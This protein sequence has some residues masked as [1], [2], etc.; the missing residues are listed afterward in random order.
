MQLVQGRDSDRQMCRGLVVE[1]KAVL[2]IYVGSNDRAR[3]PEAVGQIEPGSRV[4][5]SH[6]V[7]MRLHS[8]EGSSVLSH[9]YKGIIL[10]DD[11]A[12]C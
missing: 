8:Y 5:G 3:L 10:C 9:S 12:V 6:R 1:L 11:G 7:G 4:E 2:R